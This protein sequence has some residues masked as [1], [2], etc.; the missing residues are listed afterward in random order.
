MPAAAAGARR[1]RHPPHL[2]PGRA[3][4]AGPQA[5][6]PALRHLLPHHR[7]VTHRLFVPYFYIAYEGALNLKSVFL[8]MSVCNW[9]CVYTTE[10]VTNKFTNTCIG[11][12]ITMNHFENQPLF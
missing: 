9:A 1:G 6:D 7:Y 11:S 10:P 2:L 5:H 8:K 3:L 12:S 4:H